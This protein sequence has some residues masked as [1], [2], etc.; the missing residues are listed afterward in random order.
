[1]TSWYILDDR[2]SLTA[3]FE[4]TCFF[5]GLT[6]GLLF[7]A[8]ASILACPHL[9]AVDGAQTWAFL[10]EANSDQSP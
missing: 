1:L 8:F 3:G 9:G 5:F 4:S 6:F 7:I 10:Q 2:L